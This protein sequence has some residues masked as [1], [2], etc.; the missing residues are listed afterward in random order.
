MT[1]T[2][3]GAPTDSGAQRQ[4]G[5]P[6]LA[7]RDVRKRLRDAWR[8]IQGE[9]VVA[10]DLAAC[11]VERADVVGHSVGGAVALE[12]ALTMRET[13]QT[14]VLIA[15]VMPDRPFDP[16]FMDNLRQVAR[17]TRADG[18]AAAMRSPGMVPIEPVNAS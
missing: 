2:D 7:M 5:A 8:H 6:L 13:V 10:G 18:I 14:L 12:M 16:E 17:V 9:R 4:S 11:G 3:P 1:A 15:P